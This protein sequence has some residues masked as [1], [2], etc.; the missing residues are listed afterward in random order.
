M[1]INAFIQ[2]PK[3]GT[4]YG[5]MMKAALNLGYIFNQ[6]PVVRHRDEREQSPLSWMNG[7]HTNVKVKR[8][9]A[10]A[11]TAGKKHQVELSQ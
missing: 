1:G 7:M 3:P 2:S 9:G 10:D 6:C 4:R 8:W 5:M 11:E